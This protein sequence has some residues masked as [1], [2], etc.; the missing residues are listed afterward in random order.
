MLKIK[1]YFL[2]LSFLI[3][4][5]LY[6]P[7]VFAEQ[8]DEGQET[9]NEDETEQD[10]TLAEENQDTETDTTEEEGE[11][12]EFELETPGAGSNMGISNQQFGNLT[13]EGAE[14]EE[15]LPQESEELPEQQQNEASEQTQEEQNEQQDETQQNESSEWGD[16]TLQIVEFHGYLRTR[17]QLFHNLDLGR[18]DDQAFMHPL[19]DGENACTEED[20]C[21][22][23]NS[24]Y[25]WGNMRFRLSPI[26]NVTESVHIYSQFDFLDNIVL[27]SSPYGR[28]WN[29]EVGFGRD[30]WYPLEIFNDS[31]SSDWRDNLAN[32]VSIKRVWGEVMTPFNLVLSFGRMGSHWG[33]GLMDNDGNQI[34]DNYGTTIDRIM[35]TAKIYGFTI[36]PGIDF[37]DEGATTSIYGL[38]F[39]MDQLDDLNQYFLTLM[40]Q[41][42][43][44]ELREKLDAGN[45]VV[46]G[47]LYVKFRN[48]ALSWWV[49][50][51]G[52]DAG[53]NQV[54]KRDAWFL[55]P[56]LW[57]QL[58]FKSFRFELEAC[59]MSGRIGNIELDDYQDDSYDVISFGG[60]ARADYSLL[61]DQL[62]FGLEFGYATGD[63]ELEG[64]NENSL[65]QQQGYSGSHTISAFR[66]NPDF[67]VDFI[68]FEQIL[69]S[70]TSAYYIKPWIQYDFLRTNPGSKQRFGARV[71]V[72][73][74]RASEFIS[75]IGNDSNL[76]V[77]LDISLYYHTD[78]YV[79]A[80]LKYGVLFPLGAFEDIRDLQGDDGDYNLD[81][82]Q[83]L[84]ALL[85][86]NF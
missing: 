3:S 45:L 64:L 49:Q 41:L 67:N 25:A 54:Y 10:E 50:T 23:S 70:V 85:G 11:G 14:N 4:A 78:N 44:E 29:N 61:H 77:E 42:D 16:E 46:Q 19:G 58:R 47:G 74:S 43:P 18:D 83:T 79:V 17:F 59:F 21:D 39:D 48:Q 6:F 27:G 8:A 71:D 38:S 51:E 24:T 2:M 56:D 60:A 12:S 63:P 82:A 84:Q 22:F 13:L 15:S 40:Y 33:L 75:T 31:Q 62:N 7:N 68:L 30:A 32:S 35:L 76:G 73:Y 53:E 55:I 34:N 20:P 37:T 86:I 69:G 80:M 5:F 65:N 72:I 57:F 28:V 9:T 66:F 26:I 36:Q 52:D 81:N 1:S